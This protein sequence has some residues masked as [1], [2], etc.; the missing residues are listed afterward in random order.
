MLPV[1]TRPAYYLEQSGEDAN[2]FMTRYAV[3]GAQRNLKIIGIFH[4]LHKRDGKA[5]YLDLLPRVWAH[6]KHDLT[7]P[8]LR[9]VARFVDNLAG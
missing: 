1:R 8:V 6:L 7:H 4:R 3:L 9:D 2:S 5:H